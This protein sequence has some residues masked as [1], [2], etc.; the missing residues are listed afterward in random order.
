MLNPLGRWT[1]RDLRPRYLRRLMPLIAV[2]IIIGSTTGRGESQATA[3]SGAAAARREINVS[4]LDNDTARISRV[5]LNPTTP[6]DKAVL[7]PNQTDILMVQL[8]PGLVETRI[9]ERA[10]TTHGGSGQWIWLTKTP[11]H[12]VD[13]VGTT[14]V[15]FIAVAI[16]RDPRSAA[17]EPPTGASRGNTAQA[18][19]TRESLARLLVNDRVQ[20]S[21]VIIPPGA[22]PAMHPNP[23]D[24]VLIQLTPGEVDARVGTEHTAGRQEIGK[25]YWIPTPMEHAIGNPGTE[26]LEMLAVQI[27]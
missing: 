11:P 3:Q 16:K 8:S 1:R 18:P 17:Q 5:T 2:S 13:N 20:V 7:H 10:N 15:D 19:G 9:G 24:I 23:L 14:P 6:T 22:H 12:A 4:I 27:K 21:R 26:P 25:V